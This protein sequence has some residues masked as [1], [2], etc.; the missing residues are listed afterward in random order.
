MSRK[1][2]SSPSC[3]AT[4]SSRSA[5]GPGW[6]A[7]ARVC[8][9]SPRPL[10][11]HIMCQYPVS[12]EAIGLSR[13]IPSRSVATKVRGAVGITVDLAPVRVGGELPAERGRRRYQYTRDALGGEL[14]RRAGGQLDEIVGLQQVDPP[15]HVVAGV[16]A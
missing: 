4:T 15:V 2:S 7:P 3:A 14:R 16:Q 6:A 1:A 9:T 8:P 13:H 11:A 12:W 10:I 5:P